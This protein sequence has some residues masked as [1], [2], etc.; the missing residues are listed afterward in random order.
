MSDFNDFVKPI[1]ASLAP[2]N[3]NNRG[4]KTD[5]TSYVDIESYLIN[6]FELF[7]VMLFVFLLFCALILHLLKPYYILEDGEFKPY[8][9]SRE[10]KLKVDY[11]EYRQKDIKKSQDKLRELGLHDYI[12]Q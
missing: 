8:K 1:D 10:Y 5:N 11:E 9:D 7:V 6:A 12:T 2:K 3:I 4:Q